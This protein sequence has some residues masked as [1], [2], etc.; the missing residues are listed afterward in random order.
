MEVGQGLSLV[1][2]EVKKP[3]GLNFLFGMAHFI[4]TPEDLYEA[5]VTSHAS[6]KF[7]LAVRLAGGARGGQGR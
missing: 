4:K 7:G 1:I 2:H 3:A 6:V 5:L